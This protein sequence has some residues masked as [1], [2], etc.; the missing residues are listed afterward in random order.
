MQQATPQ[1][2]LL[3]HYYCGSTT[4]HVWAPRK[5]SVLSHWQRPAETAQLATLPLCLN[6]AGVVHYVT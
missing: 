1:V 3:P 6:P 4:H 5:Y 2:R